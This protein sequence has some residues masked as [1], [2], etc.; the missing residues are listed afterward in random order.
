MAH[1]TKFEDV[2]ASPKYL[3]LGPKWLRCERDLLS[4]M[5][6]D[7]VGKCLG[8][9]TELGL[10][11]GRVDRRCST[12]RDGGQVVRPVVVDIQAEGGI[13]CGRMSWG[14]LG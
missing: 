6:S 12:K 4:D 13:H 14:R 9:V 8:L 5:A 11:W 10:G 1:Y 3:D 7:P 2:K